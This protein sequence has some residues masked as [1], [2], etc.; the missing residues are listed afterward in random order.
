MASAYKRS[1]HPASDRRLAKAAM[2]SHLS[3]APKL[4]DMQAKRL[5][6]KLAKQVTDGVTE[7]HEFLCG[8]QQYRA[9]QE[10]QRAAGKKTREGKHSAKLAPL[11]ASLPKDQRALA[12]IATRKR[13]WEG[14]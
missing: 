13:F 8:L 3:S 9:Y 10:D 14:F 2:A 12:R 1:K 4:G 6:E 5:A 11:M 7:T